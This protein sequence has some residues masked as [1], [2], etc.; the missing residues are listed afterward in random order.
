M[1][2]PLPHLPGVLSDEELCATAEHLAS[3]QVPSGM[4]PWFPEGHC[5]PWNHVE[6]AMALDVAGLHDAGER[7]YEWLAESQRPD[8]S[9]HNY[10]WPDGTVEEDKV[11]TNVCAYVATGVWHHWRCTWERAFLDNLWPTVAGALDFV[12][13]QRRADGLARWAVEADGTQ[14]WD[15]ALL[16]G[17]SS[18]QHAL[19]CGAVL[20]EA[21]GE[22]RPDWEA[23]ADVMVDAIAHRPDAFEPKTAWAMD[24][25]YPVLTGALDGEAAK[26]RLAESWDVFAMEGKGIR[27]VST[28]PWVT[29]SETAECALAFAAIGDRATATDLLRWTRSHRREDGSYWTGLVWDPSQGHHGTRFPFEEH[30]SYTA[31]AVILAADAITGASAA[32]SLFIPHRVED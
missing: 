3:L 4:I 2:P 12:L 1:R 14:T 8:G 30:T 29:A 11:D 5:D 9:W 28:D 27:C 16:T 24:W 17:T 32:S 15:Y 26:A 18:I 19:R 20:G 25:Y 31:A 23:A 21:V 6:S 7:A 10:Y 13:A 22:P